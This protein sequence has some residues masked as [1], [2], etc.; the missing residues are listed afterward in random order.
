MRT[1]IS[2]SQD[3]SNLVQNVKDLSFQSVITKYSLDFKQSVAFEI[4]ACSFLLKSLNVGNVSEDTFESFFEGNDGNKIKYA[5]SLTG[6][7]KYLMDRVGTMILLC[8]Y[9]EWEAQEKAK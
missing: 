2:I 4:I 6:L 5:R 7:R 8:F 9:L 3:T 1:E